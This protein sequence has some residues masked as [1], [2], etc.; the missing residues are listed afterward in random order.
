M[1][2][3]IEKT[4]KEAIK[5]K[6]ITLVKKEKVIKK[7]PPMLCSY[8]IKA[9]IST[10]AYSNIQPEITVYSETIEEAE[11]ILLPHIEALYDK[12]LDYTN[13]PKINYYGKSI[14][15]KELVT[16]APKEL[17]QEAPKED[18]PYVSEPFTKAKN[19]VLGCKNIEAV[20]LISAKIE[21]SEKLNNRE[22]LD[23]SVF[24]IGKIEELNGR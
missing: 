10:G 21:R 4:M 7:T 6:T 17:V 16:E 2:K 18:V 13:R 20:N 12:Y 8:T 24:I 23:L 1:K 11:K 15:P 14:P 5:D 22:K 19:A 9:T 3:V